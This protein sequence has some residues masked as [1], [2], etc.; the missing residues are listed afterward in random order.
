[1][2]DQRFDGIPKEAVEQ[3]QNSTGADLSLGKSSYE[4][5]KEEGTGGIII[6]RR[7]WG[8]HACQ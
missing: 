3:D 5:T 6:S 4:L 2:I 7:R 8:I 1:M